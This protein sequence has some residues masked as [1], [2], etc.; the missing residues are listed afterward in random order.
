MK[1]LACL[2]L[3]VLAIGFGY[4]MLNEA[5]AS[6]CHALEKKALPIIAKRIAAKRDPKNSLSYAATGRFLGALSNGEI[7][8][9]LIKETYTNV[10]PTAGCAL[11]YWKLV[12]DTNALP[13]DR[14]TL[15]QMGL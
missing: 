9:A 13:L 15:R 3:F 12:M 2:I 7:A 14:N 6:T 1:P 5:T 11:A 4:P 8:A 10:P